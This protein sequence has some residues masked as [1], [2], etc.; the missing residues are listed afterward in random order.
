MMYNEKC[1]MYLLLELH[2]D[3]DSMS[4]V[5]RPYMFVLISSVL[6]W[7]RTKPVDPVTSHS[8][9]RLSSAFKN[10]PSSLLTFIR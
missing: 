4:E 7:A 10:I 6:T 3:M 2:S 1:V 8:Y 9:A 5:E